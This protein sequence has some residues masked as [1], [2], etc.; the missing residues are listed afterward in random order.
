MDFERIHAI[1]EPGA[2]STADAI[3][4]CFLQDG[5]P[6]LIGVRR[7]EIGLTTGQN[8]G[9]SAKS[10]NALDASDEARVRLGLDALKLA[11]RGSVFEKTG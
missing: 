3:S 6:V 8:V 9:F 2:R 4:G 1:G 7:A 10:P 11:R 5:E